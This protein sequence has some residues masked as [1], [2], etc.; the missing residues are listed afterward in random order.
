MGHNIAVIMKA[1]MHAIE[2]EGLVNITQ[3]DEMID[4]GGLLRKISSKQCN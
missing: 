1:M 4:I 2:E 3:P